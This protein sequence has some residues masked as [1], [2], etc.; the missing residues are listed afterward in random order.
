MGV[1]VTWGS[2]CLASLLGMGIMFL[3]LGGRRTLLAALPKSVCW[4]LAAL[5]S[6]LA[7]IFE[8]SMELFE[9][10]HK[11]PVSRLGGGGG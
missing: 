6:L 9:C 10:E 7:G 3:W 2:P 1:P 4:A 8:L 11:T 5:L